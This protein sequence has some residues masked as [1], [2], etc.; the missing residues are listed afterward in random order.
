MNHKFLES[1]LNWLSKHISIKLGEKAIAEPPAV[2]NNKD[3]IYVKTVAS[4]SNEERFIFILAL[5][6]HISPNYLTD[7][8]KRRS[9]DA[10]V[11]GL[12]NPS[13]YVGFVPTID[14]AIFLLENLN[15]KS[16]LLSSR[17]S[18]MNC[19]NSDSDLIKKG[20]IK[21][22]KSD[23]WMPFSASVIKVD[24][25]IL[26]KI[27][28]NKPYIPPFSNEFPAEKVSTKHEWEDLVLQ[29]ST[30][31]E[32]E[33]VEGWLKHHHKFQE[34]ES[35]SKR[36]YPGYRVIFHGPSGTGKT[37][38]VTLLGK[39]YD[40]DVYRVDLSKIVSKYIGETEKNLKQ[41]F[42]VAEQ[43]NWILFFDEG[44]ALFGKRTETKSSNDRY[45]N[46]E[47]A[48]LLQRIERYPGMIIVAT[49][50]DNNMDK[51]FDRRFQTKVEFK[52][53]D[54]QASLKM[55]N[56]IFK[57]EL[58][59]DKDTCLLDYINDYKLT[60]GALVNVLQKTVIRAHTDSEGK[61][62]KRHIA[63]AICSHLKQKRQ[64]TKDKEERLLREFQTN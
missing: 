45:A 50:F 19:F 47:I 28:W 29:E 13:S 64:L 9:N 61:V 60:G 27:L 3:D 11:G 62:S 37:L 30:I 63:E 10:S 31:K 48:Y 1:D 22:E 39:K 35:L 14:T 2:L 21:L 26:N 15:E 5:S 7:L 43:Q 4:L 56:S 49:N 55:Y 36:L 42:D 20:L 12:Y 53:P 32:L 23:S 38:A 41:V 54:F 33:E 51:A 59:M 25:N 40:I 6:S 24:P 52:E 16:D 58:E 8:I 18:V 34:N 57:E 17:I 44:D 46:Q